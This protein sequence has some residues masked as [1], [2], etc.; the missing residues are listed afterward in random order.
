VWASLDGGLINS[1]GATA[2]PEVQTNEPAAV[3]DVMKR[4]EVTV[5]GT[6]GCINKDTVEVTFEINCGPRV[7]LI[8]STICAGETGTLTATSNAGDGNYTYEYFKGAIGPVWNTGAGSPDVQN[9]A[10]LT[11]T[12]Y[13]VIVTD[14]KGDKDTTTAVITVNPLPVLVNQADTFCEDT[15]G[16][17]TAAGKDLTIHEAAINGSPGMTYAWFSD[18]TLSSSVPNP[19]N[20]SVSDGQIFYVLVTNTATGCVDTAMVTYTVN[21]LPIPNAGL[22]TAICITETV[23]LAVTGGSSGA[24]YLW[25]TATDLDNST[26]ATPIFTGNTAGVFT[27]TVTITD[28]NGCVNSDQVV[29]TVNAL[30]VVGAGLDQKICEGGQ[31]TLTGS[32]AT[33]YIWDNGVTDGVSFMPPSNPP[34]SLSTVTNYT[35]TGTDV[36][37]CVNT[38]VVTV[39]VNALPT[40]NAGDDQFICLNSSATIT[41]ISGGLGPMKWSWDNGLPAINGPHTVSPALGT[42]DYVVTVTDVNGCVAS[43]TVSVTVNPNPTV[44]AG[45]DTTICVGSSVVLNASGADNYSWKDLST[46]MPVPG[47]QN[48]TVQPNISTC[49]EVTGTDAVGCA[50]KD[51]VCVTVEQPP[52]INF[53]VGNVC[54]G[55]TTSIKNTTTGAV[56]YSWDLGDGSSSNVFEPQHVYA[57][58]GIYNITLTATSN[59][60]CVSTLTQPTK[61]KYVPVVN[62]DGI[63]RVGCP[64]VNAIFTNK[65]AFMNP[66]FT[67]LWDFG[68]GTFSKLGD[69]TINHTY[70][71]TGS[72]TVKL[73]VSV[74]GC[75]NTKERKNYVTVHPVPDAQ[76]TADPSIV[77]IYNPTINFTDLSIGADKWFWN[78]GDS[79]E[80]YE[81]HPVHIYTDTGSFTVWLRVENQFGCEDSTQKKVRVKDVYTFFAPNSFTPDGDGI[82]DVFLPQGH[83]IDMNEYTL[84]IFDRWGELIFET[85]DYYEGWDGTLNGTPVQI[86]TYVWKVDLQDLF[87]ANHKYIGHKY[88]GRVSVIR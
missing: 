64:P 70:T 69:T 42:T 76:F 78:F 9:D 15:Q 1:G 36:N 16:S 21:S 84:Y 43:D 63:Q 39:T 83:A 5:N 14:G 20:V 85:N 67:Y 24:T 32:G 46:G 54:Q 61:V 62:F 17:G 87:G 30:P 2:T 65:T 7:T 27:K 11:T 47:G 31:V 59:A 57:D 66:S 34:P 49:Y 58:S 48:I 60:G 56:T 81:Q 86:D 6:N 23:P 41:A 53:T 37:G 82:N 80:G 22:D 8:G 88:I 10:P 50:N 29:I 44:G 45:K 75:S 72:Y 71:I 4:Y 35:V 13:T 77:D 12:T 18:P 40:P 19:S 26:S 73:T 74:E 33:S 79:I 55:E 3:V 38:D 68:D 52:V 28:V 25:D 51:V